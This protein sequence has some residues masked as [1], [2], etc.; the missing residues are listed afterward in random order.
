[1]RAIARPSGKERERERLDINRV[2]RD[3]RAGE[4]TD[5]D[6]ARGVTRSI[7]ARVPP[8]NSCDARRRAE[9]RASPSPARVSA[10]PSEAE[11]IYI[12]ISIVDDRD[13]VIRVGTRRRR[14][15]PR[16]V[17]GFL[18][19][20]PPCP[21]YISRYP[22]GARSSIDPSASRSRVYVR[23]IAAS[24]A[25]RGTRASSRE[26]LAGDRSLSPRRRHHPFLPTVVSPV[27]AR[28]R[29]GA[30]DGI[31]RRAAR[32]VY[33]REERAEKARARRVRAFL[34]EADMKESRCHRPRRG[35]SGCCHAVIRFPSHF[36]RDPSPN[37]LPPPSVAA[38]AVRPLSARRGERAFTRFPSVSRLVVRQQPRRARSRERERE[39]DSREG[40]LAPPPTDDESSRV[41]G[42]RAS[43]TYRATYPLPA[44]LRPSSGPP[45]RRCPSPETLGG[46]S[47][48]DGGRRRAG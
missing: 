5:T 25:R 22:N 7:R 20:S 12:Y 11:S 45:F 13:Y 29:S 36:R 41:V 19:T 40:E 26:S 6:R 46:A 2:G 27:G 9:E 43:R 28:A 42:S 8:R 24:E 10:L 39:R 33:T 15:T 1:M 35:E 48:R 14:H 3:A 4:A 37:P 44:P 31:S 17:Y 23:L 34:Y 16:I 47:E 32:R 18:P 30:D 21:V 38:V